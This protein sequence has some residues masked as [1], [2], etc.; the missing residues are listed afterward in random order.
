MVEL[1]PRIIKIEQKLAKLHRFES[2]MDPS[3]T[4]G[5]ISLLTL[6]PNFFNFFILQ[7]EPS[8]QH[9]Q[10][11]CAKWITFRY[12]MPGGYPK[13]AKLHGFES[14]MWP[15]Y[16]SCA[17]LRCWEL[18]NTRIDPI[19]WVLLWFQNFFT[20][21]VDL[22]W[23][24]KAVWCVLCLQQACKNEIWKTDKFRQKQHFPPVRATNTCPIDMQVISS[25]KYTY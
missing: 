21:I 22:S 23:I 8:R 4:T 20:N 15:L 12:I 17:L 10:V 13:L 18:T 3:N 25:W 1:Y 11:D 7:W 5:P 24:Y 16:A 6:R 14:K 9:I 19:S 2:Q